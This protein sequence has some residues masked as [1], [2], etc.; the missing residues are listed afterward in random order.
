MYYNLLDNQKSFG[1]FINIGSG[2][3]LHQYTTPYGLSKY[4]IHRSMLEKTEFYNLRIFAIFD[5]NEWDTRFI[6]TNINKYIKKEPLTVYEDK[7]MDF[8]YMPDFITT[9]AYYINEQTPPKE[10]NCTYE[11]SYYL[12]EIAEKINNLSEYKV[13]IDIANSQH[14]TDYIGTVTPI[15]VQ[16]YGLDY[17]INI[18][19][20]K[21]LQKSGREMWSL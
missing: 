12:S 8:F 5:E 19:Y 11:K 15:D 3:E 14:G 6:K 4:V 13:D 7:R 18:M 2:A 16:F 21:L 9:V 20:Q 10:F 1:R 17:G